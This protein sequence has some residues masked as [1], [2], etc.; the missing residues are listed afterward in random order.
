MKKAALIMTVI[1]ASLPFPGA[2]LTADGKTAPRATTGDFDFCYYWY[3]FGTGMTSDTWETSKYEFIEQIDGSDEYLIKGFMKEALAPDPEDKSFEV[4]TIRAYYNSENNSFTIPGNQFLY[5]YSDDAQTVDIS[6]IGV[7]YNDNGRLTPDKDLDITLT[8]NDYGFR[9][10]PD[11]ECVA[12]LFGAYFENSD[13]YGGFGLALNS[14]LCPWN[15]TMIYMVSPSADS[16]AIPYTCNIWAESSQDKLTLYNYADC[17]YGRGSEFENDVRY[18]TL[19]G[20]NI[21]L[22]DLQD[23]DGNL[24]PLL[25][26]DTDNAGEPVSENGDYILTGQYSITGGATMILQPHWSAFYMGQSVGLYSNVYT[27]INYDISNFT[28]GMNCIRPSLADETE[29]AL[30]D[31]SGKPLK[32]PQRGINIV[33]RG[34]KFIKT[35]K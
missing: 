6:V 28:S 21:S 33:K 3:D 32:Q 13:S 30:Y 18:H 31:L 9:P 29:T 25:A 17:G 34:G 15:G 26:A 12:I 7:K 1:A 22:Q 20:K 10:D 24:T 14:A 11:S 4:S 19:K 2:A 23:L 27:I 5:R 35:I 8:W 16:E